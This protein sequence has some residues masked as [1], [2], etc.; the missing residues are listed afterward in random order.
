[1]AAAIDTKN[2]KQLPRWHNAAALLHRYAVNRK[3]L[4]VSALLIV[5]AGL[6]LNWSWL[7][8]AGVAP[9]ILALAPCAAMCALGMCMSRMSDK[10]SCGDKPIVK[11]EE[12]GDP[13]KGVQ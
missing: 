3:V 6:A 2:A 9:I 4:A 12:P 11:P 13:G 7:V 1:M 10:S 5:G 8:A